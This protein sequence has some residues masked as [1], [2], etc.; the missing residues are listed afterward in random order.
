M[1]FLRLSFGGSRGRSRWC[2]FQL[3]G[4]RLAC[5][6][7][8][9]DVGDFH[10][11]VKPREDRVALSQL[12]SSWNQAEGFAAVP[13]SQLARLDAKLLPDFGRRTGQERLKQD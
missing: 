2:S 5:A 9:S 12:G 7:R 6:H 11:D 8:F 1:L 13:S 10:S 4:C 3:G